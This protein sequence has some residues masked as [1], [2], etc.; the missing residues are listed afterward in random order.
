[1]FG[2]VYKTT[3]LLNNKIYIGQHHKNVFDIRYIGSGTRIRA[4]QREIGKRNFKVEVI[5]WCETLEKLCER[6]IYWITYYDATNPEIGYNVLRDQ[7]DNKRSNKKYYCRGLITYHNDELNK[8]IRLYKNEIPPKGFIKGR[9]KFDK[10]WKDS[11][12]N[13]GEKNGMYGVHRFGKDN[14]CWGRKWCYNPETM[15]IKYLKQNES[16]PSGFKYGNPRATKANK[17]REK[18]NG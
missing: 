15:E 6:E 4:R 14:P 18:Q 8:E 1:M 3:D 13:R 2:Y 9:L 7:A 10:K 16:L 11:L 5:E 17:K 12:A